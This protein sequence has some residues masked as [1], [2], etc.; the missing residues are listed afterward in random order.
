MGVGA[1]GNSRGTVRFELVDSII[2]SNAQD[3]V[4]LNDVDATSGGVSLVQGC[5]IEPSGGNTGLYIDGC[6]YLTVTGNTF[7]DVGGTGTWGLGGQQCTNLRVEENLFQDFDDL[8]LILQASNASS[9]PLDD[10][11]IE[12]N[13]FEDNATQVK[14]TQYQNDG[15]FGDLS[16]RNNFF[17][18]TSRV[19]DCHG[20][21]FPHPGHHHRREHLEQLLQRRLHPI[22]EQP[23]LLRG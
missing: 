9:Q 7:S 14:L 19:G 18:G 1:N 8:A 2:T 20:P 21:Q 17:Q 3:A 11:F 12:R 10:I 13:T 16:I 6:D 15:G 22:H 4:F 23:V 5:T